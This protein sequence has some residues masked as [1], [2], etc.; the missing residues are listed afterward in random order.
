MKNLKNITNEILCLKIDIDLIQA[1]Q[2]ELADT[3]RLL[4]YEHYPACFERLSYEDDRTFLEPALFYVFSEKSSI[5]ISV[6]QIVYGYIDSDKRPSSFASL[7]DPF[8]EVYLGN[9]GSFSDN[10]VVEYVQKLQT[11]LKKI[12]RIA[13]TIQLNCHAPFILYTDKV[14]TTKFAEPVLETVIKYKGP[15]EAA[16]YILQNNTNSKS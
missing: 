5:N 11:P 4:L 2:I 9:H 15:L 10:P 13:D 12:I 14:D 1:N 3:I 16:F 7:S 6:D 8:G